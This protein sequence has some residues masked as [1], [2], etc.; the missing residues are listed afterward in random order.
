MSSEDDLFGGSS[1]GE[2]Q[3]QHAQS[4]DNGDTGQQPAPEDQPS[5]EE[6]DGALAA[7]LFG[8]EDSDEDIKRPPVRAP[9]APKDSDGKVT[10]EDE[11]MFGELSEGEEG[12]VGDDDDV[13]EA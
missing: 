4:T 8:D 11:D 6:R 1:D 3:R 2:T 7:D 13:N 10:K 5:I 12:E 9:E